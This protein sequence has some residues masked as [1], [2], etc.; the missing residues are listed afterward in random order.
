MAGVRVPSAWR[1][2]HVSAHLPLGPVQPPGLSSRGETQ[3]AGDQTC[4]VAFTLGAGPGPGQNPEGTRPG[5]HRR[6]GPLHTPNAVRDDV[7]FNILPHRRGSW[8]DV[9]AVCCCRI[10]RRLHCNSLS[11]WADPGPQARA[12]P[13]C[14]VSPRR[15]G[16]GP[17]GS[18]CSSACSS[19]SWRMS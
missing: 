4:T 17:A 15:V 12:S 5:G 8:K 11:F 18:E 10:S 9:F 2:P 16:P 14:A 7:E 13:A 3:L 19:G 1:G 6:G